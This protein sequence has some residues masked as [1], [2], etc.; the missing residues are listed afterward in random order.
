MELQ[1]VRNL[2]VKAL[3]VGTPGRLVCDGKRAA[4]VSCVPAAS[5]KVHMGIASA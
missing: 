1:V 3:N 4:D 5:S 2:I